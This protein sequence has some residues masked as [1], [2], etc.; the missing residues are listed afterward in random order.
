MMQ[1]VLPSHLH[2]CELPLNI[3][4]LRLRRKTGNH[5]EGSKFWFLMQGIEECLYL[6]RTAMAVSCS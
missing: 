3:S 5:V 2:P 1:S 4:Q 6:A